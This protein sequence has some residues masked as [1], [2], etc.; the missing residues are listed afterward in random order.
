M[1]YIQVELYIHYTVYQEWLYIHWSYI[2]LVMICGHCFLLMY[3]W[4]MGYGMQG[5]IF[6]YFVLLVRLYLFQLLIY[7][8]WVILSWFSWLLVV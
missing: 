3:V 1:V 4:T 2:S 5:Y 6:I 8:L 7:I